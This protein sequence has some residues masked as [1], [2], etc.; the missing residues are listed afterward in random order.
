M[1]ILLLLDDINLSENE[2]NAKDEYQKI[3][4]KKRHQFVLIPFGIR[5]RGNAAGKEKS[6]INS[7]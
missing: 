4:L 7:F 1:L 5:W 6:L 2:R 3:P